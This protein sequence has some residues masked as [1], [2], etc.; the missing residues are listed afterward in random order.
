MAPVSVTVNKQE[1]IVERD[2]HPR[3]E[4]TRDMLRDLPAAFRQGGVGTVGNST[5]SCS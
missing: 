4:T 3:P 2:E 5:V 1:V